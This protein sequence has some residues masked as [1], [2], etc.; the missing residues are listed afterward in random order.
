MGEIEV[1]DQRLSFEQ[2]AEADARQWYVLAVTYRTDG[3]E[4]H[5][6][7]T[8]IDAASRQEVTRDAVEEALDGW[9]NDHPRAKI[10]RYEVYARV[11]CR[12]GKHVADLSPEAEG[13]EWSIDGPE[14]GVDAAEL[15]PGDRVA[16]Y[17]GGPRSSIYGYITE[18]IVVDVPSNERRPTS[19]EF[20][21]RAKLDLGTQ[22]K[23]IPLAWIIGPVDDPE[24]AMAIDRKRENL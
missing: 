20:G 11:E 1:G 18:G 14:P 3:E 13:R 19:G 17:A 5:V 22:R 24:I 21:E 15:R 6:G 7:E 9:R 12:R 10:A 2:V 8:T 16:Y 23:P 4:T